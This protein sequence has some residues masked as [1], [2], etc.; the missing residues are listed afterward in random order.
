M[1]LRGT[2]SIAIVLEIVGDDT[3]RKG[4]NTETKTNRVVGSRPFVTDNRYPIIRHGVPKFRR[5]KLFF[6]Q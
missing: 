3:A 4:V 2:G 5:T 6:K 1:Y